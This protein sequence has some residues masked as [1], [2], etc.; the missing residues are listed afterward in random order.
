MISKAIEAVGEDGVVTIE[1]GKGLNSELELVDGMQFDRGYLSPYFINKPESMTAV[2][3]KPYVLCYEKKVSSI[4]EILPVL[5]AVAQSGRPMLI[6][7]EDIEGEALATLVVNKLRGILNIAAVK[8]PAFGD[9]RKEIVRDISILTGATYISE[10]LGMKLEKITLDD[11]GKAKRIEITKDHTTIIE[12]GGSKKDIMSR[13]ELIRRN[14]E[15][16]TSDYDREKLQERLA[17]LAGGVAVIQVGA[18][19]EIELKEKKARTDDALNAT[20]AAIEEGIVPGGGVALLNAR[21]SLDSLKLEGDE[22]LGAKIIYRALASPLAQIAL[23]AGFEGT[24]AVRRVLESKPGIGLNAAT[25]EFEDLV[26]N[27]I[28]DP[29]KVMRSALQNASSVAGIFITSECLVADLPEKK[30]SKADPHAGHGH[31]MM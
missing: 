3:E 7:A 28:I 23:N 1:E 11:L 20:R 30:E 9:R 4:Q 27:G 5:Q 12:G 22:A 8:A 16:T 21:K 14:I 17:K 18:A 31:G 29:V 6:I 19:T 13:C 2:L 10:D 26:K 15:T 24:V 25:N